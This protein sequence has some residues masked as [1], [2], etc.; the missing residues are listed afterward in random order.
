MHHD[1]QSRMEVH[2][3]SWS[4]LTLQCRRPHYQLAGGKV[5]TLYL[6]L[7]TTLEEMLRCLIISWG[8]QNSRLTTWPLLVWVWVKPVFLWYLAGTER[9][10]SKFSVLL[11]LPLSWS[12]GE[13]EKA[14]LGSLFHLW[15]GVSRLLNSPSKLGHMRQKE[16]SRNSPSSCCSLGPEVPSFFDFF[17]SFM[18]LCLLHLSCPEFQLYLADGIGKSTSTPSS[19]KQKSLRW[20]LLLFYYKLLNL[21]QL[22]INIPCML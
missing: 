16:N 20:I 1:H 5:P 17:P 15:L 6:T 11:G 7:E 10:F 22:S 21:L 4:P 9:L 19:Q 12:F 13:R 8:G 18:F 3:P 14:F 2:A